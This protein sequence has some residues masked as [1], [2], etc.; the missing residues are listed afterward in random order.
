MILFKLPP[1]PPPPLHAHHHQAWTGM[2]ISLDKGGEM[3]RTLIK[4]WFVKLGGQEKPQKSFCDP[5]PEANVKII[6][7]MQKR[8]KAKA[9]RVLIKWEVM[10]L[11]SLAVNSF[12]TVALE[13]K[14]SCENAPVHLNII[15]EDGS[16][17]AYVKT[18]I[19]Y[20][21]ES[22]YEGTVSTIA[23]TDCIIF[24]AMAVI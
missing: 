9:K 20:K 11:H 14:L 12:K 10:Y 21:H 17:F 24:D 18:D 8:V 7:S 2:Y 23:T 5:L 16:L 19:L 3:T 4:E 6:V 13:R 1:L 15:I 22:M